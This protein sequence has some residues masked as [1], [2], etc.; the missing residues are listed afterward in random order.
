MNTQQHKGLMPEQCGRNAIGYLSLEHIDAKY[1][2]VLRPNTYRVNDARFMDVFR[3]LP[4]SCS[5][6]TSAHILRPTSYIED[7]KGGYCLLGSKRYIPLGQ[8]LA[9]KPQ[10]IADEGWTKTFINDLFDALSHLHKRGLAAVELSSMSVLVKKGNPHDLMLMPPASP[11]LPMKDDVWTQENEY[12]APELFTVEID[13]TPA[14]TSLDIY[15]A[16]Q[17]LKRLFK[18][19][20]LP[21]EYQPFVNAASSEDLSQRPR[22]IEDAKA[23][24]ERAR[25]KR[26]II[27]A[28]LAVLA[29]IGIIGLFV[30][31]MHEPEGNSFLSVPDNS[32]D[33][34]EQIQAPTDSLLLLI[35]NASLL[36]TDS[37]HQ[38]LDT[39]ASVQIPAELQEE[40]ERVNTALNEFRSRFTV[41]ARN[42]LSS[43][44]TYDNLI[45][46]DEQAFRQKVA[47]AMS[48]L[49]Q[50]ADALA[51]ELDIDFTLAQAEAIMVVS[52]VTSEL[53]NNVIESVANP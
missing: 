9:D 24:I 33:S 2:V 16:A 45:M 3:H 39:T 34:V 15:A 40:R 6:V 37:V 21:S 46:G 53:R 44:Y 27:K 26:N 49:Q 19:S 42:T 41:M 35:E 8:L 28:S 52:R 4:E 20:Q 43:I 31:S 48:G 50:Q 51:R 11:F 32:A 1:V 13:D 25:R 7:E 22:S 23:M 14:N 18:F 38:Q 29:G 10:I 12:L 36:E 30:W 17:L 5:S 47:T